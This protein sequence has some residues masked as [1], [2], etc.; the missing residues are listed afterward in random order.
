MIHRCA[1]FVLALIVLAGCVARESGQSKPSELDLAQRVDPS[2][3]AAKIAGNPNKY[4]GAVVKLRCTISD[5]PS[6]DF[7]NATCGPKEQDFTVPSTA[8]LDV[9]DPSAIAKYEQQTEAAFAKSEAAIKEQGMLVLQGTVSDLD[10]N[11]VVTILGTVTPPMDGKNRMGAAQSFPSVRIEY[12]LKPS[13]PSVLQARVNAQK[14]CITRFQANMDARPA[15]DHVLTNDDIAHF[16]EDV[17]GGVQ[18]CDLENGFAFMPSDEISRIG[19]GESYPTTQSQPTPI[20]TA[21]PKT[22][23]LTARIAYQ[24]HCMKYMSDYYPWIVRRNPKRAHQEATALAV[25][26]FGSLEDCDSLG[27]LQSVD[28]KKLVAWSKKAVM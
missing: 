3:T 28:T 20:P 24:A 17:F 8:N 27:G 11:Q 21:P 12:I 19:S 5:V 14:A 9:T 10:A 7:A 13:S 23:P 6:P 2:V 15:R 4:V 25:D 26:L 18:R 22:S 1:C 16:L